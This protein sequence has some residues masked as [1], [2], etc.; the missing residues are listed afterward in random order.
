MTTTFATLIHIA[1]KMSIDELLVVRNNLIALL[2][3]DFAK[4]ADSDKS[5]IN[6]IVAENIDFKKPEDGEIIYK[7]K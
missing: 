5:F 7:L 2:G 3:A 1:P 6:Q 4:R